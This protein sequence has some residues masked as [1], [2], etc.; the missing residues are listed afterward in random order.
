M[1]KIAIFGGAFNPPHIGHA[2]VLEI[3]ER[4]F[5][6][7]EIW[8]MPSSSRA[9]KAITTPDKDRLAMLNLVLKENFS[10]P[11]MP[12][13]VSKLEL[14]RPKLTTTFDTLTELNKL[15]PGDEFYFVIGADLVDNIEEKWIKGKELVKTANFLAIKRAFLPVPK[16]HLPNLTILD[17][18]VIWS[19]VSST[20]VRK[21]IKQGYSG[22]PYIT[23]KISQYIKDNKLY[24][25]S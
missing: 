1:K 2:M 12:I 11:K 20:F 7:D 13:I 25:P 18:D 19:D 14:E 15:Y 17:K 10:E 9:D 21:L 23:R 22:M 4:L 16:K 24:S 6:G 3:L 8:L 5:G